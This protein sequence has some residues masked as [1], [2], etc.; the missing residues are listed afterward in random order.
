MTR[1]KPSRETL[2]AKMMDLDA[3]EC[4]VIRGF[5]VWRHRAYDRG[6]VTIAEIGFIGPASIAADRL[7]A[8]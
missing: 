7:L 5:V 6:M 2:I 1:T 8:A 4:R 3:G